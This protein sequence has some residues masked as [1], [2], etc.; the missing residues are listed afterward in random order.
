MEIQTQV[1]PYGGLMRKVIILSVFR[2][3]ML[4]AGTVFTAAHAQAP[5]TD[6]KPTFYRLTTGIYVSSRLRFT[7]TYPKD[8][9][10]RPTTPG[11]GNVFYTTPPEPRPPSSVVSVLKLLGSRDVTAS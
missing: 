10:E 11:S 5:D 7:V 4:L 6:G 9:L 3:P 1:S 8:W 2:V